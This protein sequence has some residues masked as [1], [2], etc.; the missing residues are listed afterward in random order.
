MKTV[1][2]RGVLPVHLLTRRRV[3]AYVRVSSGKDA[4]LGSLSSQISYYSGY[5]QRRIEWEFAGIY[6]DEAVTGTKENRKEFQ[7][8]LED[9]RAGR[10]DMIVTKSIT[11]FARNTVITLETVRELKLLGIDVYFEKE[12]IHSISGDGDLMLSILAGYAQEESRSVSENCK[13][14]IRKE[15][16][17][18][19][20]NNGNIMGYRL[21]D[22]QFVII[23]EEAETVRMIFTDYL[24]GMGKNAIVKK[25]ISLGI[26][27]KN[28]GK[29][30]ENNITKI[31]RNEK[32]SGDM[33]LQ[34]V[35]SEN[36]ITKKTRKNNGELPQYYVEN[37]HEPIVDKDTFQ[38]VQEEIRRRAECC[39]SSKNPPETY[40]FTGKIVC[41]QCGKNYRRKTANAGTPYEKAAW[42]CSTFNNYGKSVCG[43]Q[44]IPEDILEAKTAEI[45]ELD[46]FD[47]AVF[48]DKI[49]SVRVPAPNRLIAMFKNRMV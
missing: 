6:A 12:N 21:K 44:Q 15:F 41:G 30:C 43:S 2:K 46:G 24:S 31:L 22:G 4:M 47:K 40:P 34:K 25:L 18:G 17:E 45:L 36:H 5:I 49:S 23:P 26:P 9:C 11:R 28:G 16:A 35:F 10:L 32:Y 42:I 3:A 39:H 38:R 27:T 8:M 14:R 48:A 37:S 13:W 7:R 19:R 20:T 29:W 33:L 1:I